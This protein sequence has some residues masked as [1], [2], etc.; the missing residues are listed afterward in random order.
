MKRVS[1][2][3]ILPLL[4]TLLY[5]G[6]QA[7]DPLFSQFYAA[8]LQVNPALAGNA[9]SPRVGLNFRNQ[10]SG[11][12]GG[13]Y[14][15]FAASYDQYIDEL[16]SGVGLFVLT[17]DAGNGILKTVKVS[18][19]FAYSLQLSRDWFVKFGVEG[20]YTQTQL[21]WGKLIFLDQI[22][23]ILGPITGGGG[24]PIPTQE[25]TPDE[26][27]RSNLDLGTGMLIYNQR[28]YAG[29]SI[30][31]INQPDNTFLGVN[32]NLNTPSLTRLTVHAGGEFPLGG[33]NIGGSSSFISPNVM[34]AS[35]GNVQQ[36]NA[37]MYASFGMLFGG[38]WFRHAF[39][40]ADAVIGLVGVR[41]DEFKIGY[42]FDATV[43]GLQLVNSGGTHEL[44]MSIN[45]R[46]RKGT[47]YNDCL[48]MFR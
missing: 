42:S 7:Q 47:D 48:Q 5:S 46:Q 4:L 22:D 33:N 44:S 1:R 21:D 26:L 28:F 27:S 43:S 29:I 23:P 36:V 11:I 20:G 14:K 17:D 13:A 8:P 39:G 3:F 37:G 15:T 31:H 34:Y 41:I 45:F 30:K 38:A 9:R 6:V 24:A 25:Q 32:E 18:G 35:Q 19:T 2:F 12:S 40:N 16:N 10:W